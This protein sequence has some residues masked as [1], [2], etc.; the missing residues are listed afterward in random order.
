MEYKVVVKHHP[1][2]YHPFFFDNEFDAYQCAQLWSNFFMIPK[3]VFVYQLIDGEYWNIGVV[4][5][6]NIF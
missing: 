3:Q 6:D 5:G 4:E 2:D 1:M